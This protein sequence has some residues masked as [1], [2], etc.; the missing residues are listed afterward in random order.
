VTAKPDFIDDE[1]GDFDDEVGNVHDLALPPFG[2][3]L[4]GQS[5]T[6]I[7][8]GAP[9]WLCGRVKR[10]KNLF[11]FLHVNVGLLFDAGGDARA[12]GVPFDQ[13]RTQPWKEGWIAADINVGLA[14]IED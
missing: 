11:E 5:P 14:G 8:C 2:I 9:R 10:Q 7:N 6:F 4:E 1:Q 3:T 13:G 12:N